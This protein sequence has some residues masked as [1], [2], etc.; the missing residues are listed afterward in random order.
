MRL[1]IIGLLILAAFTGGTA[2]EYVL[3]QPQAG[4]GILALLRRYQL[5]DNRLVATF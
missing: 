1:V 2:Q 5:P 3:A 4:E